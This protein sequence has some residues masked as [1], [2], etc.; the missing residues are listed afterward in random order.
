MMNLFKFLRMRAIVEEYIEDN[1]GELMDMLIGDRFNM[2]RSE[3]RKSFAMRVKISA[4]GLPFPQRIVVKVDG[5]VASMVDLNWNDDCTA[6]K[7]LGHT[8]HAN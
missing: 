7:S 2:V 8:R 3:G 4:A 5:A 6:I 1:Y